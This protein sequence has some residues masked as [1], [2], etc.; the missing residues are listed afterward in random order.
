MWTL[1][2]KNS[3]VFFNY[4]LPFLFFFTLYWFLER[5]PLDPFIIGLQ[6]FWMWILISGAIST[7]EQRE[8]KSDAYK[9]LQTLPLKDIE[10]VSAKYIIILG[11]VALIFI[12]N[13]V[14]FSF[15]ESGPLLISLA[16]VLIILHSIIC[17]L[18]AGFIYIGVYKFGFHKMVKVFW[19]VAIGAAALMISS[20]E[21]IM[22][23]VKEHLPA[24]ARFLVNIH[25]TIWIL[26][27]VLGLWAY[28][29]LM[30][31]AARAKI[32]ARG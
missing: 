6:L 2:K 27:A 28:H 3:I 18:L 8:A 32:A 22:P 19:G 11:I 9:F 24:I 26:W 7:T 10:I 20:L 4:I 14:L 30:K 23:R 5:R 31:K 13:Q 29:G 21:M 16:R 12:Y 17:L 1:V 15:F 25:W